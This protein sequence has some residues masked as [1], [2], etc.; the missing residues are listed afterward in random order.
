M[1]TFLVWTKKH[2]LPLLKAITNKW[3]VM[4]RG[5]QF[6][7]NLNENRKPIQKN[8]KPQKFEYFWICLDVLFVKTARSDRILD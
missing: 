6:Y 2:Q 7:T 4:S 3:V 1:R 8:Q 5:A